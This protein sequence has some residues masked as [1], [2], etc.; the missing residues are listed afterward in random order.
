MEVYGVIYLLID[1]TN[2]ME[3]VGQTTRSVEVRFYEHAKAECSYIGKAIQAHGEN[4]FVKAILKECGSKEELD[5]WER[6]FI[7]SRD[8]KR[9]NGYNLTDGGEG[10]S[11][12]E[13][14]FFGKHHTEESCLEL[15]VSHRKETPY[16]NLLIEM[17]KRNMTYTAMAKIL[18]ITQAA[19]SMKMRDF[20]YFMDKD[21]EKLVAFFNLPVEYL[22][23]RADGLP[24]ILTSRGGEKNPFFGKHHTDEARM[25]FSENNRGETPYKNLLAEMDKRHISY[26]NL[27]K[28]LDM[29][30]ASISRKI[31]GKRKFTYYEQARLAE[32]FGMPIEYL[33]ARED[34]LSAMPSKRGKTQFKNLAK[35][36]QKR[37]M[38]YTDLGKLMGLSHQSV[39]EK[40]GGKKNFTAENIAKLVEIFKLPAEYL[41]ARDDG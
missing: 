11:G 20:Q 40:M 41:M 31:S 37:N 4:M 29:G 22:L 23:A 28:L 13:H 18:G 24:L 17:G 39:S 15:S 35:E 10:L 12:E 30:Y 36:M 5:F 6:Y 27:A 26:R 8:T 19:F 14:P 21:V 9:P 7:K 34:G 16:Q 1:G 2:D 25:T 33:L 38:T 32:I 3:Y